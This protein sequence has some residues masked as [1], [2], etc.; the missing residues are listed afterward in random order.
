MSAPGA[1]LS[2]AMADLGGSSL[3]DI[4]VGYVTSTTTGAGGVRIYY[5]VGGAISATAMDPSGGAV[6]KQVVALTTGNFNYT[7]SPATAAPYKT[8]LAICWRSSSV[9]GYYVVYTR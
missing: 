9:T 8:D 1:V 5:N 7:S 6:T 4:A 3:Q 2:F